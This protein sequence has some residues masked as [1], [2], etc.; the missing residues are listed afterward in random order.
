[1]KTILERIG[2]VI[3]PAV[4]LIAAIYLFRMH[5]PVAGGFCI[6]AAF[7]TGKN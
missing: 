4:F 5:A 2:L 1:M 7:L 6:L 3:V